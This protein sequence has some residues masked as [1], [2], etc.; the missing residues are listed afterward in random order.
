MSSPLYRRCADICRKIVLIRDRSNCVFCGRSAPW[1]HHI[2][3][4][5]QYRE[6]WTVMFEPDFQITLCDNCHLQT[7]DS[8]HKSKVQFMDKLEGYLRRTQQDERWELI[9]IVSENGLEDTK[10][11][12]VILGF[13]IKEF[14]ER[15]ATAWMDRDIQPDH[16]RTVP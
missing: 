12:N 11:H 7:P 13:L 1:V 15:D 10:D 6:N 3:F 8:P 4:R 16:G 14:K 2:F 5:S 9:R